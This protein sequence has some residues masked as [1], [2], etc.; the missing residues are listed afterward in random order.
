MLYGFLLTLYILNSVLLIFIILL[1][2]TKSSMG[3]GGFG[4]GSQM[5][6]G[7]SGGQDYFQK[8]TWVMGFI[9]M[10]SSLGL[11]LMKSQQSRTLSYTAPVATTLPQAPATQTE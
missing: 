2:K 3:L 10:F 1:Q 7:G 4:G 9:F 8:A 5:F 11:S 6:F